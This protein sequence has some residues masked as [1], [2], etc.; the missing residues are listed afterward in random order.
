M[1]KKIAVFVFLCLVTISQAFAA[2]IAE[3]GTPVRKVQRGFLNIA[4][5]PIEISHELARDRNK[6]NLIPGWFTGLGRGSFYMVGRALAGTWDMLTAPFP[7]PANYAPLVSPE[8]AWE[9]FENAKIKNQ[10]SK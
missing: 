1:R 2:E 9:H 7:C 3:P 5:S 6:E 8:F 4:L 10:I